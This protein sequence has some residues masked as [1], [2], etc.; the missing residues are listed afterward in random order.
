VASRRSV[1]QRSR[2]SGREPLAV[3]HRLG[4]YERIYRVVSRIPRGR[5]ATYGQ[6]ASIA[7]VSGGARQVGYALAALDDAR[8]PWHRVVNYKGGIS[9]R[10]EPS[11]EALQRQLLAR[12]GVTLD[13]AGRVSLARFRWVERGTGSRSGKQRRRVARGGR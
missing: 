3:T 10:A 13:A 1:V 8:V 4:S 11:F 12:E 2:S 7:G 5:V 9:P 6:I